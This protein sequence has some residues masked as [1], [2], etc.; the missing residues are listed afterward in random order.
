MIKEQVRGYRKKAWREK[1]EEILRRDKYTCKWCG[2]QES[3]T[4]KLH[5]HHLTYIRGCEP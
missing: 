3:D 2:R 5:V 1:R 4:V